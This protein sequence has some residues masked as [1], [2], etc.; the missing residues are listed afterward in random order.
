MHLY[1]ETADPDELREALAW[2]IIDGVCTTP[3]LLAQR[4]GE[5]FDRLIELCAIVDGPV[6]AEVT[7]QD[8]GSIIEEAKALSSL[9]DQILVRIPCTAA[10]IPAIVELSEQRITID[11][12]L[13]FSLAQAILV[14]KAGA[15]LISAPVG[16]LDAAG[17]DGLSL[18]SALLNMLD[19]YDFK[20]SIIAAGLEHPGHLAEAARM[21]AD[22]ASMPLSLLRRLAEHPLTET[23]RREQLE[24]WRR[25]QN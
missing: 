19:Q 5:H 21:G 2:R 9:S 24:L 22:A 13:C 17:G 10:G 6:S 12:T 8:T 3:A 23:T 16:A 18:V 20:T 11:A 4:G 25:A 1:V 15:R 7:S 14:A